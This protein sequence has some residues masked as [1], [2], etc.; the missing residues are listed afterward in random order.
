MRPT[1]PSPACA[2]C[3]GKTR[4]SHHD[5]EWCDWSESACRYRTLMRRHQWRCASCD[6]RTETEEELT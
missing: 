2:A 1:G 4:W 3:G 6:A 5:D